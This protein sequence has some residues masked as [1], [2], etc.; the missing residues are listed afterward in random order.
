MARRRPSVEYVAKPAV[1]VVLIVAVLALDDVDTSVRALIVLGFG[2]SLVGDV[3]LMLPAGR[4]EAGLGA[5]LAAHCF[6]IAAL[7]DAGLQAAWVAAGALVVAVGA[8]GLAPPIVRGAAARARPLAFAVGAYIT[9]LGVMAVSAVGV[10]HWAA[11]AAGLLFLVSDAL[12]GWGRFVGPTPGGRVGVHVTY[13]LA[14]AGFA[15]WLALG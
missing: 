11:A 8:G 5:F 15:T 13:H 7:F 3:V 2:F 14:Q 6:T 4:F 9:V 12:L 1:M 10:G